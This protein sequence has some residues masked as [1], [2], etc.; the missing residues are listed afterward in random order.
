MYGTHCVLT[1]QEE[2]RLRG[3][4][5]EGGGTQEEGRA[6]PDD[7]DDSQSGWSKEETDKDLNLEAGGPKRQTVVLHSPS[8]GSRQ[9]TK[10]ASNGAGR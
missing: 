2:V 4:L 7:T 5:R 10:L 8:K 9:D 1:H 6:V 3:G